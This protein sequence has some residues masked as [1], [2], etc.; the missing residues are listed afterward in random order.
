MSDHIE[1]IEQARTAASQKKYEEAESKYWLVIN[2]KVET[3]DQKERTKL[4]QDQEVA[5]LELGKVYQELKNYEKLHTLISDSRSV[6]GGF[7]KSKTAKIVKS[8]V[9]DFDA[10]PGALDVQI[11]AIKPS[12]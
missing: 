8:L 9:E 10:I 11:T 5:I 12:W 1:S 6:L 2:A 3:G 4:L 7:A